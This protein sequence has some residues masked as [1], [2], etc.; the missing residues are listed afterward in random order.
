[1]H[2]LLHM[3]L[4]FEVRFLGGCIEEIG[5]HSFQELRGPSIVANDI[6][7]LAKD[8]TQLSAGMLDRNCRHRM[9]IYL[10]LLENRNCQCAH[11]YF[12]QVFRTE[13]WDEFAVRQKCVEDNVVLNELLMVF[14]LG[15]LHPAFNYHHREF[16]SDVLEKLYRIRADKNNVVKNAVGVA[17]PNY[18]PGFGYPNHLVPYHFIQFYD[19][20]AT[21]APQQQPL[22]THRVPA[23]N[24]KTSTSSTTAPS[25]TSSTSSAAMGGG[26]VELVTVATPPPPGIVIP[27]QHFHQQFEYGHFW[28]QP[29]YT[30]AEPH[31]MPPPPQP[32]SPLVSQCTS[33]PHSRPASPSP[34]NHSTTSSS[35][36]NPHHQQQKQHNNQ[37]QHRSSS[38]RGSKNSS[39]ESHSSPQPSLGLMQQQQQVRMPSAA[40]VYAGQQ[41]QQQQQQS[42]GDIVVKVGDNET[43]HILC[44]DD[45]KSTNN[46]PPQQLLHQDWNNLPHGQMPPHLHYTYASHHHHHP[47]HQ[48]PPPPAA[49]HAPN[50]L[51]HCFSPNFHHPLHS[52]AQV[53]AAIEQ[54]QQNMF[55]YEL[56]YQQQQQMNENLDNTLHQSG[57]SS[58]NSS[59]ASSLNQSPPDTPASTPTP[60]HHGPGRGNRDGGIGE[61]LAVLNNVN[62]VP[63]MTPPPPPISDGNMPQQPAFPYVPYVGFGSGRQML[64]R[65]PAFSH[66]YSAP[67]PM[68]PHQQQVH[69]AAAQGQPPFIGGYLISTMLNA[70]GNNP[71]VTAQPQT[72]PPPP[73]SNSNTNSAS[74]RS[75]HKQHHQHQSTST[76]T[77]SSSGSSL[78]AASRN[79]SISLAAIAPPPPVPSAPIT[80]ISS[81]SSQCCKCCCNCGSSEHSD[82]EC[83]AAHIDDIVTQAGYTLDYDDGGVGPGGTSGGGGQQQQQ[84]VVVD[85]GARVVPDI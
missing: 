27:Q 53:M 29:M 25:T 18:P 56:D 54:Q 78:N 32:I 58:N 82:T 39:L 21:I 19:Q 73:H 59:N 4:P 10:A 72:Q 22:D 17:M 26:G 37:Q 24:V 33:P 9:C 81:G 5:K 61:K 76:N 80:S 48:M 11:W 50:G 66:S 60:A 75:H 42:G 55:N 49:P 31:M 74:L 46:Q 1:M 69:A 14:T 16:F 6:E 30:L 62:S 64:G 63:Y 67:P 35:S 70:N 47:H 2:E 43:N 12:K 65:G 7:R 20:S 8:S 28:R 23:V 34:S 13:Q 41:Q 85:G 40:T 45:P 83:T 38:L 77:N 79:H 51:R 15:R 52:G 44:A 3:C 36:T 68:T 57:S 84:Q 71:I